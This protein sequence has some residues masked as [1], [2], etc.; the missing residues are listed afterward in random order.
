MASRY[1]VVSCLITLAVALAFHLYTVNETYVMLTHVTALGL[2]VYSEPS[3]N[4]A[5]I[6]LAVILIELV[7]GL[8]YFSAGSAGDRRS[9]D[10]LFGIMI[11]VLC[12]A[13]MIGI[14]VFLIP[15]P[16]SIPSTLVAGLSK[17]SLENLASEV[18]RTFWLDIY[19]FDNE[20][21]KKLS[22]VVEKTGHPDCLLYCPQLDSKCLSTCKLAFD[23][24]R[25]LLSKVKSDVD[26]QD[27]KT[28][29]RYVMMVCG[30]NR[31]CVEAQILES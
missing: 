17:E 29:V 1:F 5:N 12:Y 13:I 23:W 15:Q 30:F 31:D 22:Y 21:V 26:L 7:L 3:S 10:I 25:E 6:V 19:I 18:K 8:M 9:L 14:T 2:P 11:A 24:C 20:T 4:I 27:V 28:C 16:K